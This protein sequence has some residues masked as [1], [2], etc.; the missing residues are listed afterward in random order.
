MTDELTRK[1]LRHRLI[2]A[3]NERVARRL[4]NELPALLLMHPA[5][6]DELLVDGDPSE[7]FTMSMNGR[8]FMGVPIS[9]DPRLELGDITVVWPKP[10]EEG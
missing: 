10:A 1:G 9:H 5:T 8:E 7:L 3:R 2:R 6:H 4:P